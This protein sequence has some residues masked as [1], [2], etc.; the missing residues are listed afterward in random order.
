[1]KYLFFSL[2]LISS[3]NL[4]AQ[5]NSGDTIKAK[6]FNGSVFHVGDIKQSLLTEIQFQ[7]V[8]GDCWV[9]LKGQSVAGTDYAT[10]TG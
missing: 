10:I 2:I 6:D 1:M 4:S 7:Q 9:L 8:A 3:F 5:V